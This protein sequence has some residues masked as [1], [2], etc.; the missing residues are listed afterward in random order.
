VGHKPKLRVVLQA[1]EAHRETPNLYLGLVHDQM[2]KFQPIRIFSGYWLTGTDGHSLTTHFESI[3]GKE[4]V[5]LCGGEPTVSHP[6]PLM[7]RQL[8]VSPGAIWIQPQFPG[9]RIFCRK[10]KNCSQ[11]HNI[12]IQVLVPGPLTN[13]LLTDHCD[14]A[15][16]KRA[17]THTHYN[18]NLRK[19]SSSKPPNTSLPNHNCSY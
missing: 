18:L 2:I 17:S 16:L 6:C 5:E 19:A 4:Q 13:Y 7:P 15:V 11:A 12:M 8:A 14:A 10:L 9:V 3:M 1:C